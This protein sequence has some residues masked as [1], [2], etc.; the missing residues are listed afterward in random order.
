MRN[1]SSHTNPLIFAL[2]GALRLLGGCHLGEAI[3]HTSRIFWRTAPVTVVIALFSGALLV[4]Q[5]TMS[6]KHLGGGMMGAS[7]IGFGGVREVF[8][9]LAGGAVATRTGAALASEMAVMKQGKQLDALEIMGVDLNFHLI[10]PRLLGVMIATP[11]CV[12]VADI[13]G[14]YGAFLA[15]AY[16]IGLDAGTFWNFLLWPISNKDII[17]GIYKGILFGWVIGSISLHAGLN[18][19][20][21]SFAVG[22]ATNRAIVQSMIAGSLISLLI[23][24]I[25]YGGLGI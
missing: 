22:E 13:A 19:G 9:L 1:T 6:L 15:G 20:T 14:L 4:I 18:V 16:Q 17:G 12:L 3:T 10:G 8:P 5:T 24:F 25:V 2:Y 23:S 11:L 7:V 21:G